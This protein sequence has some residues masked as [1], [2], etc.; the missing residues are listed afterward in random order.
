MEVISFS[1]GLKQPARVLAS[2]Q[3]SGNERLQFREVGDRFEVSVD[4]A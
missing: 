4:F 2:I 1:H 3:G